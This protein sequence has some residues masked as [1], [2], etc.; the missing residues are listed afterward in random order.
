M[1]HVAACQYVARG[2]T[3]AAKRASD[4]VTLHWVAGG[5]EMCVGKWMAFRLDTGKSDDNLYPDQQTAV[6]LQKGRY[7]EYFYIRIVAGG[8]NV[9]EAESLLSLH[10]NARKRDIATPDIDVSKMRN[11]IPRITVEDRNQQIRELGGKP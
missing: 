2:H 4:T 11:L 8:M 7:Q 10:R 5:W 3:D 1:R 6:R 9:C